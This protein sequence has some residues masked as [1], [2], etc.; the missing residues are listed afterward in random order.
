MVLRII[1]NQVSSPN[2]RYCFRRTARCPHLTFVALRLFNLMIKL[3]AFNLMIEWTSN[4]WVRYK[5]STL[6]RFQMSLWGP[7]KSIDLKGGW[8]PICI[9]IDTEPA[10]KWTWTSMEE[11][12]GL[13]TFFVLQPP[14]ILTFNPKNVSL[15]WKRV[16]LF[17]WGSNQ[18]SCRSSSSGCRRPDD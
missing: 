16:T 17:A 15:Q 1:V 5:L 3:D 6:V 14:S 4:S 8:S 11:W 12:G 10:L 18:P 2:P 13:R 9:W 7:N